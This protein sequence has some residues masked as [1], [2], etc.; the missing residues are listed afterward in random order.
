MIAV[1]NV[2]MRFGAFTALENV[3][4]TVPDAAVYGLLGCNGAG[5]TTL[6]NLIAGLYRPTEGKVSA[7]CGSGE[8]YGVF[9]CESLKRELFYVPDEPYFPPAATAADMLRFYGGFYPRYSPQTYNKLL[10]LFGL[11]ENKR[12]SGFS[13]GMKRQTAII[14]GLASG[15]RYLLLDESFDGLDPEARQL[16][17][18]LLG[19][20]SLETSAAVIISSH[21]LYE[22]ESICDILG[23]LDGKKLIF[24]D[25]VEALRQKIHKYSII[26]TDT[27][28]ESRL[29]GIRRRMI[30]TAGR[31]AIFLSDVER[32]KLTLLLGDDTVIESEAVSLEDIFNFETEGRS[33]DIEDIFTRS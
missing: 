8:P 10:R 21:N 24:S 22:L 9:D 11:E 18:S 6:L 4:L 26:T 30:M 3:S 5:K 29:D 33:H 12:L 16:V 7:E 25:T 13:K 19:E 17:R 20:Y 2:T 31:S 23:L 14:G 15:A 27:F 32:D 28:D 1:D